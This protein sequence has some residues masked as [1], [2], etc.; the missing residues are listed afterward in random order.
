[1]GAGI[2]ALD[3]MGIR[4][5]R[6]DLLEAKLEDAYI[7]GIIRSVKWKS[8]LRTGAVFSLCQDYRYVL[9]WVWDA[10]LPLWLYALLNPSTATAWK[11]DPTLTRCAERA[12]RAGAGGILI[13]NAGA[14]RETKSNLAV[15]HPDPIGCYNPDWLRVI[16]PLADMHIAG[17][18]PLA[19]KFGGDLVYASV[20]RELGT[21]LH[22]LE[23]TDGG[24]PKHPLYTSYDVKPVPF[25]P[26]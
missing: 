1:M 3:L 18:G 10:S 4:M 5:D 9:W 13:G 23:L 22:R 26:Y 12:R 2:S 19:S 24:H 8:G 17:W 21:T 14:I 16:V 25:S 7:P 15:R 20:F 11:L 6:I